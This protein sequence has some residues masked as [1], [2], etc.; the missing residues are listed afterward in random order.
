MTYQ[1]NKPYS[2]AGVAG[3]GSP[4]F[5]VQRSP[6]CQLIGYWQGLLGQN[7][8]IIKRSTC[9]TKIKRNK[10]IINMT[11]TLYYKTMIH[12]SLAH[13]NVLAL[14]P[15]FLSRF[16]N[17]IFLWQACHGWNYCHLHRITVLSVSL[18]SLAC[19]T[20]FHSHR[21]TACASL[22]FLIGIQSWDPQRFLCTLCPDR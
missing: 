17:H 14:G 11:V 6:P 21:H 7:M 4:K 2:D 9:C 3:K 15:F 19:S 8:Q 20:G 13:N 1:R 10:H 18:S 5:I 12:Q 16:C 22:C